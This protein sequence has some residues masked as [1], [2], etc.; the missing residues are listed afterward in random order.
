MAS[1]HTKY[2]NTTNRHLSILMMIMQLCGLCCV[3]KHT[4]KPI[5]IVSILMYVILMIQNCTYIIYWITTFE[6]NDL[7]VLLPKLMV[8]VLALMNITGITLGSWY[9]RKLDKFHSYW[10]QCNHDTSETEVRTW[11]RNMKLYIY[12]GLGVIVFVLAGTFC[13]LFAKLYLTTESRGLLVIAEASL[14]FL[15]DNCILS[16]RS[17]CVV[18]MAVSDYMLAMFVQY[19]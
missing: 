2:V 18:V 13:V 14:S 11:V 5:R 15:S 16:I 1:W 8:L 19:R 12:T 10:L 7:T 17:Q 9:L 4:K 3:T 6:E